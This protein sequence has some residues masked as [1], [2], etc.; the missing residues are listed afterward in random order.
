MVED[1]LGCSSVEDHASGTYLWI[2]CLTIRQLMV[3][4]Q[5]VVD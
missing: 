2:S 4:T 3:L 5:S 1:D